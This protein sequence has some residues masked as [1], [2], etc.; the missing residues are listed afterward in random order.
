MNSIKVVLVNNTAI[1]I[2]IFIYWYV[3]A[4]TSV[5][6][7][8]NGNTVIYICLRA[9][10]D[11]IWDVIQ[12]SIQNIIRNNTGDAIRGVIQDAIREAIQNTIRDAT[13]NA[14]QN[15][16]SGRHKKSQIDRCHFLLMMKF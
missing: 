14:I 9:I 8:K 1:W 7:C 4:L 5:L 13:P 16:I 2:L 11:A 10:Q 12:N 6:K 15:S 3:K